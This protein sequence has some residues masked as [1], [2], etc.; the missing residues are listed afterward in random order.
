MEDLTT[1][2]LEC[3]ED[4]YRNAVFVKKE[5]SSEPVHNSSYSGHYKLFGESWETHKTIS[6]QCTTIKQALIQAEND[7]NLKCEICE[8]FGLD[9]LFPYTDNEAILKGLE[10]YMNNKNELWVKY[11]KKSKK[12]QACEI[13]VK[14]RLDILDII[15]TTD[16]YELYVSYCKGK[17]YAD[18]LICSKDEFNLL[19]EVFGK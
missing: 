2:A 14:R 19:K 12:E 16:D 5:Y 11:M 7:H 8:L 18:E 13:I 17:E 4:I 1:K 10:E 6:E 15:D 9:N 3:L